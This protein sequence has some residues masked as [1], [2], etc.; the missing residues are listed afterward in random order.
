MAL[1]IDNWLGLGATRAWILTYRKPPSGEQF[2]TKTGYGVYGS[3]G[4]SGGMSLQGACQVDAA[5]LTGQCTTD[6]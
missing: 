3:I 6:W 2:F 5:G 4:S 1:R